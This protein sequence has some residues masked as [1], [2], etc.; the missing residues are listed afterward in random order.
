MKRLDHRIDYSTN[1]IAAGAVLHNMCEPISNK[2]HEEWINTSSEPDELRL[3]AMPLA[4]LA[5]LQVQ[6]ETPL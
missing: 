4:L 3:Q 6:L 1:I 5:L 2:C